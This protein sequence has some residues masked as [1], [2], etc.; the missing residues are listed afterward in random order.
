MSERP[1]VRARPVAIEDGWIALY[2]RLRPALT[3]E[4]DTVMEASNIERPTRLEGSLTQGRIVESSGPWQASGRWWDES[5]WQREEWDVELHNG[6]VLRLARQH[7]AWAA[8]AVL[9]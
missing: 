7:A 2:R 9:D 8:E 3:V 4:V 5:R 1:T 6:I